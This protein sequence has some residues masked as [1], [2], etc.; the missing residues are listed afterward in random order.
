MVVRMP[1]NSTLIYK[2]RQIWKMVE[3]QEA[4]HSYVIGV[5]R[6]RHSFQRLKIILENA[7]LPIFIITN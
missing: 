1:L 7:V 6:V 2:S 4:V 5:T 3:G